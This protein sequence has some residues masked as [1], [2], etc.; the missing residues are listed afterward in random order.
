M[1]IERFKAAIEK[2]VPK[3]KA[4]IYASLEALGLEIVAGKVRKSDILKVLAS[5]DSAFMPDLKQE[6]LAKA[7]EDL[8]VKMG[9]QAGDAVYLNINHDDVGD[10]WRVGVNPAGG[11]YWESF[12][13]DYKNPMDSAKELI[14]ELDKSMDRR[15]G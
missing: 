8:V 11:A 15:I 10:S 3:D 13:V 5:G 6:K 9:V 14:D 1:T 2:L 12:D 4:E 7:L